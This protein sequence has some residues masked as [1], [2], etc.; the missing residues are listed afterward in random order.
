M[1]KEK[2][3]GAVVGLVLGGAFTFYRHK[4]MNS[5]VET[6]TVLI[7]NRIAA[8]KAVEV[9]VEGKDPALPEKLKY[10]K[11]TLLELIEFLNKHRSYITTESMISELTHLRRDVLKLYEL[12][13]DLVKE[14]ELTEDEKAVLQSVFITPRKGSIKWVKDLFSAA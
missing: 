10:Y 13:E 11:K 5:I 1:S 3:I 14:M 8:R 6:G 4:K 7:Q 2:I 12:H 9:A